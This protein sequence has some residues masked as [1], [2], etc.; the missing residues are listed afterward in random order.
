MRCG[1]QIQFAT[2]QAVLRRLLMPAMQSPA[3]DFQA[4]YLAERE[5]NKRLREANAKLQ[6]Q[7][8][9]S[10]DEKVEQQQLGALERDLERATSDM[11]ASEC[12]DRRHGALQQRRRRHP[13]ALGAAFTE[14]P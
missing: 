11:S 10:T 6:A 1:N 14:H 2:R 3:E 8:A 7:L 12:P 4:K 9:V 5:E 13:A